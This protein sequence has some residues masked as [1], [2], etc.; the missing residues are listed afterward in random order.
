MKLEF[1]RNIIQIACRALTPYTKLSI[2][3][4]A[5]PYKI[6]RSTPHGRCI[7][8]QYRGDYVPYSSK[9]TTIEEKMIAARARALD[10]IDLKIPFL[11]IDIKAV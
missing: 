6:S 3:S 9:L 7:G 2:R 4:A 11:L 8:K 10:F 1:H 5:V